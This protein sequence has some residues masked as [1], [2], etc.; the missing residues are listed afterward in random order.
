[1]AAEPVADRPGFTEKL[2]FFAG[3]A[4][5][6][7]MGGVSGFLLLYLTDV[8]GIGAAAVGTLMLVA[9]IVDGASDPIMGYLVDH[10]PVTRWGRFRLYVLVGGLLCAVCL[11]ALFAAPAWFPN[12]LLAA[13]VTY[14]LWGLLLDLFQIPVTSL[15][16]VVAGD[17]RTRGQLAG[18]VGFT[19]LLA[20]ALSTGL[21]LPLVKLL[22]GGTGGWLTYVTI[23]AG[24]GCVLV[25]IMALRV[26][27]RVVP[28]SAER[29]RLSDVRRVFFSH[30]AVPILL[31]SKVAVQAASGSLTAAMPYFFLYYIGDQDY[32]TVAALV[33]ALPMV[34]GALA[35]PVFARRAGAKP[36][37][38]LSLGLSILG[39]ALLMVVPPA[40]VPV[41]LCFVVT[42]FGFGG[43]V[44]LGLVLLA[45]LADYTE[46]RYGF[47]TEASLAAM[48]SFATKAGAGV[49]GGLLAYT[50]A[51]TGYRSG[52]VTQSPEAVQG[53][54]Y[55]QSL[56][57]A[58]IGLVG[59][60]AFAFY[61]ITHSV[62][63][64]AAAELATRKAAQREAVA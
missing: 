48:T 5:G 2:A 3:V 42:G 30:R 27:E 28:L 15:L 23:V 33:M 40:P 43:A 60:L 4:G 47:R 57:P 51:L 56:I 61:P 63:H 29:Y 39:L 53:I 19:G 37:Y 52:G 13:W 25:T 9:R 11:I 49:G 26:R 58:V 35:V 54:L 8:V 59:A 6:A 31:T 7:L 14:L 17:A 41:M 24:V 44:A 62:A 12:A 18:I 22:G 38:L 21:T 55:A 34:I 64:Q 45:E 32:L 46:W 20:A 1:M 10:L 50:L 36:G 16:P